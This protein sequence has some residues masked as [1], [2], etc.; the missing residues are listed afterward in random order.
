MRKIQEICAWPLDSTDQVVHDFAIKVQSCGAAAVKIIGVGASVRTENVY[1]IPVIQPT[2]TS[3]VCDEKDVVVGFYHSDC[4]T[5]IVFF[6]FCPWKLCFAVLDQDG[7]KVVGIFDTGLQ[8]VFSHESLCRSVDGA[9]V[10]DCH[11]GVAGHVVTVKGAVFD[12]HTKWGRLSGSIVKGASVYSDHTSVGR[13]RGGSG[14]AFT[15]VSSIG[16]GGFQLCGTGCFDMSNPVW[17]FVNGFPGKGDAQGV[18]FIGVGVSFLTDDRFGIG[19]LYALSFFIDIIFA[20]PGV[21]CEN[22]GLFSEVVFVFAYFV[23]AGCHGGIT[24]KVVFFSLIGDPLV[25]NGDTGFIEIVGILG[26]GRPAVAEHG[27]VFT[28]VI[29]FVTGAFDPS[30]E[31]FAVCGAVIIVAFVFE[32]TADQAAF[33]VVE[34]II[35]FNELPACFF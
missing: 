4:G 8:E 32:R 31:A 25:S 15:A 13:N 20:N 33:G 24:E 12:T 1:H 14:L 35:S 18:A 30:G 21:G 26:A 6:G 9:V 28:I 5:W 7:T 11:D 3:G 22:T 2:V 10:F 17:D 27:S 34:V 19:G 29:V 23:P 16:E